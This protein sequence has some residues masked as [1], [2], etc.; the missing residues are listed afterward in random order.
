MLASPLRLAASNPV[1]DNAASLALAVKRWNQGDLAGYLAFYDERVRVYGYGPG[2]MDKSTVAAF[3]ETIWTTLGE[4]GKRGPTLTIH[5]GAADGDL[6]A[7][8]V[9]MTGIHRGAFLGISPTGLP[10]VLH[11]MTMYRFFDG[12]IVERWACEDMFG[13]LVQ[14]GAI[15]PPEAVA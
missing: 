7:C 11:G 10:Y 14:L 9:S 3:Y 1:H 13:L 15:E 6:F 12:R 4:D 2:A 5:E 8:R